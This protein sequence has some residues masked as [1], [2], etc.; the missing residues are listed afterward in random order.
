[1]RLRRGLA[2]SAVGLACACAAPSEETSTWELPP[3][4]PALPREAIYYE[5]DQGDLATA[6]GILDDVWPVRGHPAA[7]LPWPLTW[8][9]DPHDD[10]YFRF[11]FYSL[12]HTEHLLW[13]YRETRDVRYRE[14]LFAILRSFLAHDADRPYDKRKI[15]NEHAT[16]YRA[17]V[18]TNIVIKLEAAR[19]LPADLSV[20][21]RG[22]VDRM[23]TFLM[24]PRRFESWANH[25]FTEAAALLVLGHNFPE[26]KDAATWRGTGIARLEVMRETNIDPDGVDIENS[27]FYHLFVLGL[28]AQIERW[29][30]DW[31]PSLAPA[32]EKTKRGMI[33]YLAYV[34]LPNGRLPLLGATGTSIVRNQDPLVYGPLARL[35]DELAWIWSNGRGGVPPRS[36]VV[37]FPSSGLFV[38]RAP[39]AKPEQTMVTF[40]AGIY[41]T[42]HS[43]LDGLSVTLFSDGASLLPDAGLFTYGRGPEYDYFHG[44]RAHNTVVVDGKDQIEGTATAGA[45]GTIGR[46]TWATGSSRLY[47]G[48][49]HDR[50]V[51][52][53]EQGVVLVTDT[54]ESDEEHDY[55]QTW[56]LFP[57]G[58]LRLRGLDADVDN[59]K[60]APLM[61]LRQASPDGLVVEHAFGRTEA[62]IQ[63]WVSLAYGKKDPIHALEYRRRGRSA[64]FATAFVIGRRARSGV[65]VAVTET[66]DPD[67]SERS[68]R[69]A[70]DGVDAVVRLRGEGTADATVSVSSP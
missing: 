54:L 26:A 57:G 29:A 8:T 17:M 41:R 42:D 44:T 22:C 2:V 18:V 10:A 51:V 40:D 14:K 23:A 1:M 32:W 59:I 38:L 16:A 69:L 31:E 52:V 53:L 50:T 4:A 7:K 30:R 12:R 65:P 67:R 34:T 62:P 46:S 68:V 47:P 37:L 70:A 61:L 9:E 60:G 55:A 27:P 3:E 64:T 35:D 43:H 28:V 56:H 13:A 58:A 48:V 6:D 5:L 20:G 45:Y 66:W 21:L 15:D 36:R 33:R 11:M 39:D 24:N 19:E 25:G 63:G 49:R